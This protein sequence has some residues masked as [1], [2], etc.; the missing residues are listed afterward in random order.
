MLLLVLILILGLRGA[1]SLA[2]NET[3]RRFA[4]LKTPSATSRLSSVAA[5]AS[6]LPSSF[7]TPSSVSKPFLVAKDDEASGL[8]LISMRDAVLLS[9]AACL[10]GVVTAV[11]I[12]WLKQLVTRVDALRLSLPV[13]YGGGAAGPLLGSLLV[14]CLYCVQPDLATPLDPRAAIAEIDEDA[15]STTS[16]ARARARENGKGFSLKRQL[17]R[18]L[19]VLITVGTGNALA[20]A[21]PAAELGMVVCVLISKCLKKVALCFSLSSLLPLLPRREIN[22][23]HEHERERGREDANEAKVDEL[24]KALMLA[25]AAAGFSAN[26]NAPL[27]AIMYAIEITSRLFGS[28]IYKSEGKSN[29]NNNNNKSHIFK[30][31]KSI[32]GRTLILLSSLSAA[33]VIRKGGLGGGPGSSNII[34]PLSTF[35]FS[36]L[37]TQFDVFCILALG[38]CGGIVGSVCVALRDGFIAPALKNIPF[39]WRPLIGG[40]GAS[41]LSAMAFPQSLSSGYQS[42]GRIASSSSSFSSSSYSTHFAF[43]TLLHLA[44]FSFLKATSICIAQTSGLIGGVFTPWLFVGGG[45]GALFSHLSSLLTTRWSFTA[46]TATATAAASAAVKTTKTML[47]VN[48]SGSSMGTFTLIGGV[49]VLASVFNAPYTCVLLLLEMSQQL[50]LAIPLLLAA[51]A[52]SVSGTM[53]S[54]LLL[55]LLKQKAVSKQS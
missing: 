12:R 14:C 45:L 8:P 32:E 46:T 5:A 52:A 35:T 30:D 11:L 3:G 1:A 43:A 19:A 44:L 47:A 48:K 4:F 22:D 40:G 10:Q 31:N 16:R 26:F 33:A 41:V 6:S 42:L 27:A 50:Q 37:S 54:R 53:T 36:S 24:A 25:G 49:T 17:A 28:G 21:G 7:P 9:T 51:S 18:T 39:R 29:N 13:H 2:T 20:L 15:Y 38:M 55:S 34:G 23:E